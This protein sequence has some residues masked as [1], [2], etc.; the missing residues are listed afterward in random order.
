M[1]SLS[2]TLVEPPSTAPPFQ[3]TFSHVCDKCGANLSHPRLGIVDDAQRRIEELETQ[4]K[5]L[6]GK[7]TAAVDKLADYEDELRLLKSS[8]S[9]QQQAPPSP[10]ARPASA[11]TR[12]PLQTRLSSLLPSASSRRSTS[13]PASPNHNSSASSADLLTLL[14]REQ[15]LR[16]AAESRISQ[17]NEELEELSTQLFTEANEMVAVERKAR[18]KL[19]ERVKILEQ[20]EAEKRSRLE[21]LEGRMARIERVRGLLGGSKT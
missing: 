21:A 13:Q 3:S 12:A 11:A 4:V 15:T 6:T 17:T 5:I 7:A 8:S 10:P 20:R 18:F 14:T 16:Q 19:E 9:S 1:S 2:A